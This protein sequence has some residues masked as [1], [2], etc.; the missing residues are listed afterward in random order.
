M[1]GGEEHDADAVILS[2]EAYHVA[3]IVRPLDPA[4]A[5]LL[6]AIPYASSA[7]VTLA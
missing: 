6:E 4:L 3:R 5:H 2:P 1:A 7:T